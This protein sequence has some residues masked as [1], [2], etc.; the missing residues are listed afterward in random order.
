[1]YLVAL[2]IG[3]ARPN[4]GGLCLSS[5]ETYSLEHVDVLTYIF[6][7]VAMVDILVVSPTTVGG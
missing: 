1:M 5:L 2:G 3:D 4:S 6:T 7:K